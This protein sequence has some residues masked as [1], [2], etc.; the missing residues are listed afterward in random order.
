V[1]LEKGVAAK[2]I[3][4][5]GKNRE[6]LLH[7]RG[8]DAAQ[9][10]EKVRSGFRSKCA[11]DF[12]FDLHHTQ[13]TFRLIVIEWNMGTPKK[14][15]NGRFVQGQPF[16]QIAGFAL[17]FSPL[18]PCLDSHRILDQVSGP[19]G[20]NSHG[21]SSPLDRIPLMIKILNSSLWTEFR[22]FL[23]NLKH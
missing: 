5:R 2:G 20:L 18:R 7:Q 21:G 4:K 3:G 16:F 13:I 1:V 19:S 8:D 9:S 10:G 11:G 22:I 15:Q 23:V 6:A 14:R 12:L 17:Y